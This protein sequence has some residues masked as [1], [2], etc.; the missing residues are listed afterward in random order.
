MVSLTLTFC[1]RQLKFSVDQG[2]LPPGE[3]AFL[4]LVS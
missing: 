1:W 2:M 4:P 3:I